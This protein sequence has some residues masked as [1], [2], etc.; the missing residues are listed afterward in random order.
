MHGCRCFKRVIQI[1]K[2]ERFSGFVVRGLCNI[3]VCVI[4]RCVGCRGGMW[5]QCVGL[6]VIMVYGVI[7]GL[8]LGW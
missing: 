6:A 3:A 8:L 2:L 1:N 7:G 5:Y 4:L